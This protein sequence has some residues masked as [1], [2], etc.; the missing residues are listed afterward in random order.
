MKEKLAAA[1]GA[2]KPGRLKGERIMDERGKKYD[3]KKP[4][5]SP[6]TSNDQ[7]GENA[8]EGRLMK[9]QEKKDKRRL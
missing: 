6:R 1:A 9:E 7:L 5:K 2:K 8:G 3:D 4:G